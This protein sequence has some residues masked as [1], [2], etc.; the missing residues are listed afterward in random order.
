MNISALCDKI[1]LQPCVKKRVLSFVENFDFQMDVIKEYILKKNNI[2]KKLIT[3]EEKWTH[4]CNKRGNFEIELRKMV[5]QLL[6]VHFT[7]NG[8]EREA[9]EYVISKIYNDK[10]SKRKCLSYCYNDLFNPKK[11]NIYLKNLTVLIMGKWELFATFMGDI[12]QEDF[13]NMMG[14]LNVEGRFDAH[15]KIPC[16]E[17]ITIFDATIK[18]LERI[19]E[20]YKQIFS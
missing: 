2:Q 17:D 18:K 11:C 20:N 3:K 8:G 10:D 7:S 19:L 6:L 14:V 4:L 16:D 5:K 13:L 12:K 9:K 1:E 15:A